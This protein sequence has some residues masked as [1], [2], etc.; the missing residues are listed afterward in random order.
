MGALVLQQKVPRLE[1]LPRIRGLVHE[2][3]HRR[4]ARVSCIVY[5]SNERTKRRVVVEGAQLRSDIH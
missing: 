4:V 3:L 1:N 5:T 2:M